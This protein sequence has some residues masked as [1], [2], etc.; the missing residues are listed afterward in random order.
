MN[1][2]QLKTLLIAEHEREKKISKRNFIIV[3][4]LTVVAFLAV[5]YIITSTPILKNSGSNDTPSWLIYLLPCMLFGL[6]ITPWLAL[7]RSN[8]APALIDDVL[9][10]FESGQRASGF[11]QEQVYKTTIPLLKINYKLNPFDYLV[12]NMEGKTFRLPTPVLAIPDVKALLSGANMEKI[13][14]VWNDLYADN[15]VALES[16]PTEPLKPVEE[17]NAFA[18]QE[19]EA[20]LQTM[21]KGRKKIVYI[22]A[23]VIVVVL[24]FIGGIQF[25]GINTLGNASKN[26]DGSSESIEA[27]NATNTKLIYTVIAA[28][29]GFYFVGF[30][31]YKYQKGKNANMPAG[32]DAGDYTQFKQRILKKIIHF[33]NPSFEYIQHGQI[34]LL[35]VKETAMFDNKFYDVRGNDLIVGKYSGVPF[36]CCDLHITHTA[37]F[38]K[39]KEE[40]DEVFCGQYFVARFNKSFN[41]PVYVY[42]KSSLKGLF[43]NNSIHNYLNKQSSKVV[44]EDPEFMELFDVY[45]NDQITARYI[46]T[47]SLMEQIKNLSRGT[48]KGKYFMVF[49]NNKVSVLYN[50]G[51]DKFETGMLT[52]LKPQMLTDF[53]TDLCSQ[54]SIINELKLNI[55]IWR[56]AK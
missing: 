54:F 43:T 37:K 53:Y 9:A 56:A 28:F 23:V 16:I 2:S 44:L 10:K 34:G 22:A 55:N 27:Y 42:S 40:P 8:K 13:N 21:E 48:K 35:E 31:Y 36:Q 51:T 3:S 33:I 41:S 7:S 39:E 14:E 12:F 50:N 45:C 26:L 18:K 29:A 30:A 46:L 15:D 52:K 19:L 5:Y 4:V 38:T 47:T 20:P 1:T 17:F 32:A 25:F 11:V 6:I 24:A 49:N